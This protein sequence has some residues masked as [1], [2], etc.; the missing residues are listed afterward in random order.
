MLDILVN[1]RALN[2]GEWD[3]DPSVN[4]YFIKINSG[5]VN[6][7]GFANNENSDVKKIMYL[8]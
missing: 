1:S 4:D 7:N 6:L 3:P 2:Y 8:K 5:T